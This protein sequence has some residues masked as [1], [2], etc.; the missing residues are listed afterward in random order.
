VESTIALIVS[1]A[2]SLLAA[3]ISAEQAASS[4]LSNNRIARLAE[5]DRPGATALAD[6][7]AASHRF[8]AVVALICGVAYVTV[9]VTTILLL[10]RSLDIPLVFTSIA[11]GVIS[12]SFV[13]SLVQTLPRAI[14]VQNPE[15]VALRF[16]PIALRTVFLLKPLVVAL[17]WP[18]RRLVGLV[19][20]DKITRH[21]WQGGDDRLLG[22]DEAP[23]ESVVAEEAL[24]VAVSDFTEKV[25]RE[26]MIPRT[27]MTCL[28]DTASAEDAVRIIQRFGYS[29]L[30]VYHDTLD[31]IRGVIYAKDLLPAILKDPNVSPMTL[32]RKPL[33]VPET[34][35]VQQL[36]LEMRDKTHLAIVA[37]EYGGTAGLVTIEDLLEE[38]V[39][40]IQDEY[41][42]EKPLIESRPDGQYVVDGRLPVDDLNEMFGTAIES[43]SDTVG[44]VVVEAAGRIPE[45]G[46]EVSIEGLLLR[47]TELQGARIRQLIVES[48]KNTDP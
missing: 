11:G 39:G 36:L 29:R 14:A 35:P 19:I 21:A 8:R 31:D 28:P 4:L 18:W 10:T 3:V 13:F 17:E 37:D 23:S 20:G 16:A 2:I 45:V 46:D 44:G 32:T 34:K 48:V 41:D 26:V 12:T 42:S 22:T 38:I 15:G 6:L 33:F 27:D 1:L 7:T 25:V 40:E 24:L 47:V 43:E 5:A 9:G 30:P